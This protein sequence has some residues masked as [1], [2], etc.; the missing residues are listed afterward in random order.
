M[1][2]DLLVRER[3]RDYRFSQWFVVLLTI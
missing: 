3:K 1:D 2:A